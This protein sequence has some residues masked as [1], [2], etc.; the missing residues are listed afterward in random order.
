[1]KHLEYEVN[2]VRDIQIKTEKL[3]EANHNDL[4]NEI[5]GLK[6]RITG[7]EDAINALKK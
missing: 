1:M 5:N 7:L 6:A 2:A 3:V 4:C